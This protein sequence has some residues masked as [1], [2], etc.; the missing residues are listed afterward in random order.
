MGEIKIPKEKKPGLLVAYPF[1]ERFFKDEYNYEYRD[2]VMDS[3]AFSAWSSGTEID[4]DDYIDECKR[5]LDGDNPPSEIFA[6][7]VIGEWRPSVSNCEKMWKEGIE[8]IPT[9]HYGS[10]WDVLHRLVDNYP[11][12]AIGGIAKMHG[13]KRYR[14]IDQVFARAW[15][16]KLHGFGIGEEKGTLRLPWHS[17][18][19]SVWELMPCGF[20]KW[21]TYGDL[22]LRGT[23][24]DLRAELGWYLNLERRARWKWR[25]EMESLG[26]PPGLKP[27]IR[28]STV[29]RGSGLRA[30][31]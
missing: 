9:F 11:K 21:R 3:G 25:K 31:D 26:E 17:V 19:S 24:Q 5:L 4:L 30:M 28:L 29:G 15:P 2:W 8:A 7:D 6:L 23:S 10:P 20:G 22:T 18:D 13:E 12:V 14:F 16:K 1:V 27:D